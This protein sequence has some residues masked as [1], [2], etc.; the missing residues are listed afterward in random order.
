MRYTKLLEFLFIGFVNLA[1][2]QQSF[3]MEYNEHID[4]FHALD[5][6]RTLQMYV[7]LNA[8]GVINNSLIK[9]NRSHIC[10]YH[11]DGTF[12][13]VDSGTGI[14][15][16]SDFFPSVKV[17]F[18]NALKAHLHFISTGTDSARFFFKLVSDSVTVIEKQLKTSQRFTYTFNSKTKDIIQIENSAKQQNGNYYSVTKFTTFHRV[19]G[20]LVPKQIEF[21]NDFATATLEYEKVSFK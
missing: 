19:N 18:V 21:S 13:I 16:N 5:T 10:T 14:K 1:N 11:S 20:I 15:V 4:P 12:Q 2:G 3:I 9:I 7:K 17:E 6:A 8:K